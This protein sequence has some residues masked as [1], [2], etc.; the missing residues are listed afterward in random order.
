MAGR[1][2][3]RSRRR[4]EVATLRHDWFAIQKAQMRFRLRTLLILLAVL[5]PILA[6]LGLLAWRE[7]DAWRNMRSV[8]ASIVGYLG[9]ALDD[10]PN[11][12]PGVHVVKTVPGGPAEADGLLAGDVISSINKRPC[13]DIDHFDAELFKFAPGEKLPLVVRRDGKSMTLA[14]TLG[15]RPANPIADPF[16]TPPTFGPPASGITVQPSP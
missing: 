8:R 9:A 1:I 16:A 6:P 12:G 4:S 2:F 7:Y 14:V 5:P 13:G 3:L 15:R 11:L 10:D